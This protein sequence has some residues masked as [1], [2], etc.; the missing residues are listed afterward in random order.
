MDPSP[1]SH[2][3]T[4]THYD[5]G[6]SICRRHA[7]DEYSNIKHKQ[8]KISESV[9]RFLYSFNV[10]SFRDVRLINFLTFYLIFVLPEFG[11]CFLWEKLANRKPA[12]NCSWYMVLW[13][14]FYR[15][16]YCCAVK[17][18]TNQIFALFSFNLCGNPSHHYP[19]WSKHLC[20]NFNL[21]NGVK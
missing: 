1:I 10:Y 7:M 20:I 5:F 15:T 8:F 6:N 13:Y 12:R 9:A 3:T 21:H 2:Q 16:L 14:R 11:L 18:A 4:S 19:H 17:S